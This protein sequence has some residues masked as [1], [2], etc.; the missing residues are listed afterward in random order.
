MKSSL[1]NMRKNFNS[2]PLNENSAEKDPFLQFSRWFDEA[3]E[4]YGNEANAMV[5]AT[6]DEEGKPDARMVLLKEF[7]EEG[8][9]FFTN[10]LSEKG[11]QMSFNPNVS[12]LFYWPKP[13]RQV[14]IRGQAGM[15]S[16]KESD[17][18]FSSRPWENNL[19]AVISPQSEIIPGRNYLESR[20]EK[21]KS[22]FKNKNIPRPEFWNGYI[23]IPEH[24]EF[25]QGRENRLHDRL[26]YIYD[27]KNSGWQIKRL[28]P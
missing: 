17:E 10:S 26:L 28:A 21:A 5:L 12:L 1:Y 23:V 13:E 18:Y 4:E 16:R 9:V 15:I 27:I 3:V 22:D 7:S 20:Y 2:E 14:R 6:A 19:S 24:F 25:W 11:K 8:F